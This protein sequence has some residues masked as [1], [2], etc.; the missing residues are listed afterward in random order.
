MTAKEL[1]HGDQEETVYGWHLE[2]VG[3]TAKYFACT[4]EDTCTMRAVEVPAKS[5]VA[6]KVVRRLDDVDVLRLTIAR[7]V[8]TSR[9]GVSSDARG[10]VVR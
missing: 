1:S 3:E 10:L 8:S 4:A 6:T 7:D 2:V 9:G 5:L